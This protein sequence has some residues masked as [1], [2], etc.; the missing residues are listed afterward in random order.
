MGSIFI[1]EVKAYY[2]SMTG[3]IFAMVLLIVA[4]IYMMAWNLFG[5]YANYEYT[6][7][8]MAFFFIILTPLLTMRVV[9]EERRRKT[10]QLLYSLPIGLN[11]IVLGKFFAL[12]IVLAVPCLVMCLY[13]AILSAFGEVN[14]ATAYAALTGYFMLGAALLSIGMFISSLTEN[15]LIS[16]VIGFLAMI[17]IYFMPSLAAYVSDSSKASFWAI[18]IAVLVIC[19]II[20]RLTKSSFTALLTAVI[21]EGAN[22]V[23][24]IIKPELFRSL[25]PAVMEKLSVFDRFRAFTGGIFDIE[26]LVYLVTVCGVFVFLTIQSLEKRRWS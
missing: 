20:W 25:F 13:P 15:F 6:L 11:R 5:G 8:G 24:Y 10:D 18:F 19:A 16:A 23:L 9:A 14:L 2:S 1:R 7:Q 21:L 22:V 3:W 17:V 4:G 26:A 12:L